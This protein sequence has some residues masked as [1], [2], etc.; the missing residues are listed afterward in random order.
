MRMI[1]CRHCGIRALIIDGDQTLFFG[2]LRRVHPR[3]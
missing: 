3:A 2:H 1:F